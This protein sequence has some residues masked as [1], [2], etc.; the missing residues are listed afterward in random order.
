MR[1]LSSVLAVGLLVFCDG[2]ASAGDYGFQGTEYDQNVASFYLSDAGELQIADA[3]GDHSIYVLEIWKNTKSGEIENRV[4]FSI[5]YTSDVRRYSSTTK[6]G[7]DAL[8]FKAG[9]IDIIECSSICVILEVFS[10]IVSEAD[11]M[12]GIS[13]QVRGAGFTDQVQ[14]LS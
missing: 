1:R 13:F 6:K 3:Y 10:V 4:T 7:G 8:E 9:D 14:H 11:F 2:S 12:A 5:Y